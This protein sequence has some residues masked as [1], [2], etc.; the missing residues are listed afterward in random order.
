MLNA[1]PDSPERWIACSL[2]VPINEELNLML[3]ESDMDYTV[4]LIREMWRHGDCKH[5]DCKH[6]MTC[7]TRQSAWMMLYK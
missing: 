3:D 7:I 4:T 2:I 5:R 1:E 6:F